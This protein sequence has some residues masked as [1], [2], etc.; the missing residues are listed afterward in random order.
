VG[1]LIF[2]RGY[3][4]TSGKSVSDTGRNFLPF[5]FQQRA[6]RDASRLN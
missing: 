3:E 2:K 4:Q 6:I 5:A 1:I